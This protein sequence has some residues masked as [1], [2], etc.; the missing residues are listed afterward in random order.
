M[1]KFIYALAIAAIAATLVSCGDK[2]KTDGDEVTPQ[3]A[4][5][6]ISDEAANWA[7]VYAYTWTD[8]KVS[9]IVRY[10]DVVATDNINRTYDFVYSGT[11]LVITVT[12]KDETPY[13]FATLT[14]N[15]KGFAIALTDEWD[16]TY[17]YTYNSDDFITKVDRDG[18]N[19]SNCVITAGNIVSWSRFSDGVEQ[20]KN[21]TYSNDD[22]V[23]GI[24][25]TMSES[26]ASRWLLETG[27][28]G[29]NSV[30][31]AS[32]AQWAHSDKV[33]DLTYEADNDNNWVTRETKVYDNYAEYCDYTW[34]EIKK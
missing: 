11:S 26:I 29:K 27:L 12:K 25:N 22:N 34:T 17:V 6:S 9:Q 32:A 13:T 33:A 21:Q 15:A 3:L 30:K 8:G 19:K 7:D 5:F 10:N 24:H 2:G 18:V 28:F 1:K 23:A 4:T 14:L 20:F 31:L 16:E